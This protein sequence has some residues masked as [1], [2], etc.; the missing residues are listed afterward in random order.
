[1]RRQCG[2]KQ[3]FFSTFNE[4]SN[5]IWVTDGTELGTR[6]ISVESRYS[7]EAIVFKDRL[8]F[9]NTSIDGEELWVS[10]GTAIG[11]YQLADLTPG[12]YLPYRTCSGGE[13]ISE[14]GNCFPG[15]YIAN[16]TSPRNLTVAGDYLYFKAIRAPF[17]KSADSD[18]LFRTDG[19]VGG[20]E[21]I[22]GN[23]QDRVTTLVQ[24]DEHILFSTEGAFTRLWAVTSD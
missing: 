15:S 14:G 8:F 21:L 6:P 20:T 24:L 18:R 1:M 12:D 9:S 17:S 5:E 10:N 23:R 16:S 3:L 13:D 4:S 11:T 7:G 22:A 2:E 19:T